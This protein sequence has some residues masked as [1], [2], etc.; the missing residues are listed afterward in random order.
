MM[1]DIVLAQRGMAEWHPIE[2]APTD[3]TP[4]LLYSPEG[5]TGLGYLEA[6][7]YSEHLSGN[8]AWSRADERVFL[9]GYRPRDA[10]H[11]M[12]LPEPPSTKL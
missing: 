11:W 2:T 10:T 8:A 9:G 5:H 12:P 3:G 4:I 1:W 6:S 7:R